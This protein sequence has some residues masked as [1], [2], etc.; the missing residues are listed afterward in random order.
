MQQPGHGNNYAIVEVN[1]C[2]A[3]ADGIDEIS[4][5]GYTKISECR[6]GAVSTFYLHPTDVG[7]PKAT[8]AS[9]KG[10]KIGE[11]RGDQSSLIVKFPAQESD[12]YVHQEVVLNFAGSK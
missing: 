9:I 10:G 12:S 8:A 3:A 2:N 6:D 1:S 7:L 11:V 4:T 5:T